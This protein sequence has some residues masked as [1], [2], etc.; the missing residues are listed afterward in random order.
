VKASHYGSLIKTFS[1]YFVLFQLFR[2][3]VRGTG[4]AEQELRRGGTLT[5][6]QP[7]GKEDPG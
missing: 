1:R 2:H 7:Q 5:P 3:Q 6:A 4:A